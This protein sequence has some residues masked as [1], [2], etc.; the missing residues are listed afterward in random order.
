MPVTAT[1][2]LHTLLHSFS[3]CILHFLHLRLKKL[4]APDLPNKAAESQERCSET[5]LEPSPPSLSS[6]H[7]RSS[8]LS[9]P[10][11]LPSSFS[12]SEEARTRQVPREIQ[13]GKGTSCRR[14]AAAAAQGRAAM[15]GRCKRGRW[16]GIHSFDGRSPLS[17]AE[18]A[19]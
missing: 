16:S 11:P 19:I 12:L 3:L 13:G 9:S 14:A 4:H 10:L 7:S 1:P 5:L 6:F 15:K 2:K 17:L 8:P 18:D